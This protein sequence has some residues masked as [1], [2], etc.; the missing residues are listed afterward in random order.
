MLGVMA[1]SESEGNL[2]LMAALMADKLGWI[3]SLRLKGLSMGRPM[4]RD[5]YRMAQCLWPERREGPSCRTKCKFGTG[6]SEMIA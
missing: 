6:T 3:S 1:V 5:A 2:V 4:R